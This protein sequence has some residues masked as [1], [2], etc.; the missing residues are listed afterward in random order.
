MR[1]NLSAPGTVSE[2]LRISKQALENLDYFNIT[3]DPRYA[4][5]SARYGYEDYIIVNIRS[6]DSNRVLLEFEVSSPKMVQQFKTASAQIIRQIQAEYER[7]EEEKKYGTIPTQTTT[8]PSTSTSDEYYVDDDTDEYAVPDYEAEEGDYI[9][10]TRY[11]PDDTLILREYDDKIRPK[12]EVR[13][14]FRK[15]FQKTWMILLMLVVL[16]PFGIFLLWYFHKFKV[17][18]RILLSILFFLYFILIW[19]G[20]FGI[21]TGFNRESIQNFYTNQ[22]YKITRFFNNIDNA[23]GI[24][25]NPGDVI[26]ED[27]TPMYPGENTE[28][29]PTE[30][31]GT[32][33]F[34]NLFNNLFGSFSNSNAP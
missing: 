26:I 10:K 34:E 17:I 11:L 21:D 3:Q 16:P 28:E 32:N 4:R 23:T 27:T 29:T 13:R 15:Y 18:S 12:D 31:T 14:G 9:E 22:Q 7:K 19:V 1:E 5:I 33:I 30:S 2:W 8:I 20:F 6:K 25:D 24:Y